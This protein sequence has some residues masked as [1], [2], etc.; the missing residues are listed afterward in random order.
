MS[1]S[2]TIIYIF[3]NAAKV[4]LGGCKGF[5]RSFRSSI[6]WNKYYSRGHVFYYDVIMRLELVRQVPS[7]SGR[8]SHSFF[9]NGYVR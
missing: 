5:H 1:R 7:I 2:F 6:M 4:I 8:F 3:T 9:R